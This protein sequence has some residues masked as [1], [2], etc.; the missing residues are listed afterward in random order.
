MHGNL[1]AT[2][3]DIG[4]LDEAETG[5]RQ[6]LADAE[7]LELAAHPRLG[8]PQPRHRAHGE[9]PPRRGPPR[10]E[11][12]PSSSARKQGDQRLEGAALLYLSTI[13]YLGGD[14]RDSEH[15][16]RMAT[17]IL[18]TPLQ[19]AALAALARAVLA[20]GR[21]KEALQHARMANEL[22]ATHRPRRGLRVARPPRR[23]PRRS[24]PRARSSRRAPPCAPRTSASWRAPAQIA[25]PDWRAAFLTR[26]LD[27]A[28]TVR[29]AREWQIV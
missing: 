8:A 26:I 5:L 18:P 4:Q 15:R 21:V 28:R 9:R 7:R 23:S 6:A 2:W 1:A 25:N 16:A 20:A 24:R 19:P 10:R 13:A 11:R 29:L 12:P 14:L 3:A 27:N 22:L 17:E